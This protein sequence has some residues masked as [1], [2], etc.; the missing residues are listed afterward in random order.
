[1]SPPV[2]AP[3]LVVAVDPPAAAVDAV[4]VALDAAFLLE[5]QPAATKATVN[6]PTIKLR[7]RR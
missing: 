3:A 4:V 5:L 1:M 6:E 2:E 7:Q